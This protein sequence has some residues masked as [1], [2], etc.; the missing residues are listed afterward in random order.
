MQGEIGGG[1]SDIDAVARRDE[2]GRP[3]QRGAGA[4]EHA[5]DDGCSHR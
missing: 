2:A 1:K 5:E 3:E 4:A